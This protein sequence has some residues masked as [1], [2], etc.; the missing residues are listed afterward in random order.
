VKEQKYSQKENTGSFGDVPRHD[1]PYGRSHPSAVKKPR[2]G[3]DN[4]NKRPYH[5]L[6][7]WFIHRVQRMYITVSEASGC[8]VCEHSHAHKIGSEREKV[9]T[10]M[11]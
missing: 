6:N 10:G 7:F 5:H 9:N 2:K 4:G 11:N 1:A 8:G 3:P